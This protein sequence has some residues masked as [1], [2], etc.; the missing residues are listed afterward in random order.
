MR[1]DGSAIHGNS[2]APTY[3]R[4]LAKASA[5]N[6]EAVSCLNEVLD[7]SGQQR[8]A[9]AGD[10][11]KTEQTLSKMTAGTQAFGLDDF[12]NL[13]R[14]MQVCW[15]KRYGKLL[16]LEVRELDQ[17]QINEEAHALIEQL[18]AIVK[19]SKRVGKPAM[20]RMDAPAEATVRK[21]G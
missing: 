18:T 14:D 10:I 13:P 5:G 21:V 16:G 20:A 7:S 19:L 6:S 12:E 2:V 17:W 1:L 9:I 8:K 4:D 3:R 11:G 15:M